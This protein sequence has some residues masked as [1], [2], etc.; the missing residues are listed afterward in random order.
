MKTGT[1][2]RCGSTYDLGVDGPPFTSVS[3]SHH[4][5]D[6]DDFAASFCQACGDELLAEIY[7]EVDA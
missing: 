5:D 3:V 7:D 6:R 4:D 1:C 2:S